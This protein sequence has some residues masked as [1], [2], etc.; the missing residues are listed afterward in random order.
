MTKNSGQDIEEA[1]LSLLRTGSYA[2]SSTTGSSGKCSGAKTS[3][4]LVGPHPT[5]VAAN[6]DAEEDKSESSSYL[7]TRGDPTEAAARLGY[8][9]SVRI[10]GGKIVGALKFHN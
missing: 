1:A 3:S 7:V 2:G 4:S 9:L 8:P 10:I 5:D 6:V